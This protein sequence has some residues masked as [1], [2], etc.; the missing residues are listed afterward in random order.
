MFLVYNLFLFLMCPLWI[1][2]MLWRT[3]RRREKPNWRER[4]GDYCHIRIEKGRPA[5]WLHAVSVGE[6]MAALPILRQFRA[7]SPEPFL[8]LTV[9]TSSG[10][11]T[12][13]EHA[14][15]VDCIAY[16]P[17]DIARFQLSAMMRIRPEVVA[18]METELWFNFLWAAKAMGAHTMLLNGRISDRSFPRSRKVAP[19]YRSLFGQVDSVLAQTETDAERFLALG[20]RSVEVFGNS[21]FDE[22]VD[23]LD[24]DPTWWK[25]ALGL[26]IELPV[27]VV[28]STRGSE[29]EDFVL[30]ALSHVSSPYSLV[31][32][33]RHLERGPELAAKLEQQFGMVARRSESERGRYLLLD[34][35]GELGRVYACA[36]VVLIGGG[37][38]NLGGQ[39]LL[40]PLAH[41]KPVLHG[42]HMQNFKDIARQA[43]ALGASLECA[44]PDRLAEDLSRLLRDPAE[45]ER[46][47]LAGR[48][49]V[50]RNE[51]ASRRY[52][53]AIRSAG[54]W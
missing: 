20:A 12:A 33:P 9:T 40:Q 23:G 27:I 15:M 52:A 34:T 51:G 46:R 53:E 11:R 41:G 35:Y 31:W 38:S 54:G 14:D 19:F 6:V 5:V 32:A 18:I 30:A 13:T 4:M 49:F 47:S 36:D 29:E 28:G 16:M 10:H 3:S 26:P 44:T 24:S 8:L 37:F 25:E 39:N 17:I 50:S 1:P 45:R 22:A 7:M 2:W 48:E 43:L 42:P 21:K